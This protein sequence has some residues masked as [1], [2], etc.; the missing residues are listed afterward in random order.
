[1]DDHLTKPIDTDALRS[2]LAR[3]TSGEVRAKVAC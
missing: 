1:M 2:A 3:W